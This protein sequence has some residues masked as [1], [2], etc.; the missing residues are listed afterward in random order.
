M[1]LVFSYPSTKC[2]AC[3]ADERIATQR[4]LT[5]VTKAGITTFYINLLTIEYC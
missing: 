4:C 1:G 5:G 2:H 3:S